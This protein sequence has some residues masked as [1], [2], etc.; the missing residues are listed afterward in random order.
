LPVEMINDSIDTVRRVVVIIGNV[1]IFLNKLG[2]FFSGRL[3]FFLQNS[4]IPESG[5]A[6]VNDV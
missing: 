3:A 4:K 2:E 5:L 1:G 6:P